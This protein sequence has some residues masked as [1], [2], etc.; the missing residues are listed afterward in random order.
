MPS[1]DREVDLDTF[2]DN[3]TNGEIVKLVYTDDDGKQREVHGRVRYAPLTEWTQV[4]ADGTRYHVY[5]GVGNRQRGDV[6]ATLRDE[7]RFTVVGQFD[8]AERLNDDD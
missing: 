2:L 5:S 4:V 1:T 6:S 8:H 7:R 3:L